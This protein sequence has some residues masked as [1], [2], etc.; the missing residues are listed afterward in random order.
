MNLSAFDQKSSIV[1]MGNRDL[2]IDAH[3]IWTR[4]TEQFEGK[5]SVQAIRCFAQIG[6]LMS[7]RSNESQQQQAAAAD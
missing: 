3:L 7:D 1:V 5:G 2:T 6:K 4:L